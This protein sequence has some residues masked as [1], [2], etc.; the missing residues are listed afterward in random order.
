[1]V[2]KNKKSREITEHVKIAL[3]S[4]TLCQIE[5]KRCLFEVQRG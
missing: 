3:T 2:R 5:I 1:M 4:F